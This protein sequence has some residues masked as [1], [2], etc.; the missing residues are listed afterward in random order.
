MSN[1]PIVVAEP[2]TTADYGH[3]A[4]GG[5]QTGGPPTGKWRDGLFECT[6][7]LWPSCGCCCIFHGVWIVAQSKKLS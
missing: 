5:S 7:N 4:A 1:V 3:Y 2:S 6:K